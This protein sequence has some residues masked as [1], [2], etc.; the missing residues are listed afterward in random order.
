MIDPKPI[1]PNAFYDESW[2]DRHLGVNCY[3]LSGLVKNGKLR[4]VSMY[5]ETKAGGYVHRLYKGSWI[6]DWRAP[7]CDQ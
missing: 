4:C 6:L 1:E 3:V 5:I 2:M 7:R